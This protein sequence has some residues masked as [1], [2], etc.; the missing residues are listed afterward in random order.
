ML[1]LEFY[2]LAVIIK[3]VVLIGEAV[4]DGG[5]NWF[6]F[7]D[8]VTGVFAQRRHAGVQ[9]RDPMEM[10]TIDIIYVVHDSQPHQHKSH[11]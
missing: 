11:R 8:S 7:C 10:N 5:E 2:L 6:L 4:N 3:V 9:I 1:A